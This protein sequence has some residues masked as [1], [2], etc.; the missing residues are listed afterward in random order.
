MSAPDKHAPAA[1]EANSER[2]ARTEKD[3]GAAASHPSGT[4][5]VADKQRAALEEAL[6]GFPADVMT[7]LAL[8]LF[9]ATFDDC[10]RGDARMVGSGHPERVEALHPF[11]PDDDILQRIVQCMSKMQRAGNI[12]RRNDYRKRLSRSIRLGVKMP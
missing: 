9:E 3:A 11:H 4:E 7:R 2:S 6:E 8:L 5:R 10:L 1:D 12:R